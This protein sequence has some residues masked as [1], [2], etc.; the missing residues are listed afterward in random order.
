MLTF[1]TEAE[2]TGILARFPLL[3]D[4]MRVRINFIKIKS[5][6]NENIIAKAKYS[7][8]YFLIKTF[9]S[10]QTFRRK[11]TFKN[12]LSDCYSMISSQICFLLFSCQVVYFVD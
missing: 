8:A 10:L 2:N 12:G 6:T 3:S 4:K 7:L 1:E 5:C 11:K 9:N